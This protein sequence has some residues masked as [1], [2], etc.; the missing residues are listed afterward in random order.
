MR[1]KKLLF[2]HME[3]WSNENNIICS[4]IQFSDIC[5]TLDPVNQDFPGPPR[6]HR[7]GMDT[8]G[9][10]SPNLVLITPNI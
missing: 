8:I 3:C 7:K 9:T 1:A 4:L 10:A 6:K 2:E 5:Q